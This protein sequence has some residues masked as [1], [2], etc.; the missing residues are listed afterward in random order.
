MSFQNIKTWKISNIKYSFKIHPFLLFLDNNKCLCNIKR[1]KHFNFCIVKD[2]YT[3]IIFKSGHVNVCKVVSKGNIK[4]SLLVFKKLFNIKDTKFM[5]TYKI[6]NIC[7]N[8]SIDIDNFNLHNFYEILTL[9]YK[10]KN[11]YYFRYNTN[12]F[13]ALYVKTSNLRGKIL[14][15][16]SQK[17]VVVG[18]NNK[19]CLYSQLK[20]LDAFIS[21][22]KE[23]SRYN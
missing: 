20:N 17:F 19:K 15:F 13:P 21:I 10:Y 11:Q 22:Y 23:L 6:E 9:K 8:G 4:E 18:I 3:Y 7:C 16:S 12:I 1:K 5:K 2:K 14:L